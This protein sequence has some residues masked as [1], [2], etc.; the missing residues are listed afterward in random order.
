VHLACEH[1]ATFDVIRYLLALS[2]E[3]WKTKNS[4]GYTP[5]MI[6]L[7]PESWKMKNLKGYTP[8][9]LALSNKLDEDILYILDDSDIGAIGDFN[10]LAAAKNKVVE[11]YFEHDYKCI[12]SQKTLFRLEHKDPTLKC[13]AL[14]DSFHSLY[15]D[16]GD[17]SFDHYEHEK[18]VMDVFDAVKSFPHLQ[19]LILA[20]NKYESILWREGNARNALFSVMHDLPAQVVIMI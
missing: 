9:M 19:E 1:N 13:L 16:K 2:P 12:D 3:S 10:G 20:V 14:A 5:F 7:S 15:P 11:V 6:A 18:R 17:G 8:F 4:T